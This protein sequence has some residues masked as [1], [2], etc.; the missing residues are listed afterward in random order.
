MLNNYEEKIPKLQ[1]EFSKIINLVTNYYQNL[2]IHMAEE[3]IFR[4]L[5]KLGLGLL[6]L[7]VAKQGT[8]KNIYEGNLPY[9]KTENRK[10]ILKNF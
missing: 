6:N 1:E 8:G 4:G 10:Y 2:E 5:L 3:G 9:H 7:Y